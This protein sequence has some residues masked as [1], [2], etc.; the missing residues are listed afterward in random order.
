MALTPDEVLAYCLT[1]PGARA[2]WKWGRNQVLSI[3][4]TK[5]FAIIDFSE[6][7][8]FTLGFKVDDDLFLGFT[9]RP[10]IRPAPYLARAHWVAMDAPYPLD[11]AELRRALLRSHQLVVMRLPRYRRAALLVEGE[12]P[13]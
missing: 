3:S 11:A 6:H 1:L 10:G 4:D 12:P 9:D 7:S 8:K 13:A 2:D 5:M